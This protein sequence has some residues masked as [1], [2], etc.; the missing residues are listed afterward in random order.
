MASPSLACCLL[1]LV[2][3]ASACYIQNCPLGGKRAAL[4]MDI[5]KCLS[6]GPKGEGTCFGPYICCHEELGCYIRTT[7][8]LP[9]LKESN[10]PTPCQ[11]DAGNW[12][13]ASPWD[14]L[15]FE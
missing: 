10:L 11:S 8:T 15:Q 13:T 12:A 4:D 2:A 14:L 3:L 7:E 6:C 5:R 1:C 9:C